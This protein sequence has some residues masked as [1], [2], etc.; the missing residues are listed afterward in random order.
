MAD[1]QTLK[2]K[3]R[4]T[5]YPNGKGAIN[6]TD[7]QALLLDMADGIAKLT[8]LYYEPG[9]LASNDGS[10]VSN[11]AVSRTNFIP[12]KNGDA[13]SAYIYRLFLYDEDYNFIKQELTSSDGK[14]LVNYVISD[15]R[16]RYVRIVSLNLFK[17]SI[18]INGIDPVYVQGKDVSKRFVDVQHDINTLSQD[19]S[20]IRELSQVIEGVFSEE[21]GVRPNGDF[22]SNS[23]F[24][25][26]DFVPLTKD[27]VSIEYNCYITE[28]FNLLC[29]A[30]Y[31]ANKSFISGVRTCLD[32]TR[33]VLRNNMPS[34]ASYIR[35]STLASRVPSTSFFKILTKSFL[36]DDVKDLE[37]RAD[38]L[39][40]EVKSVEDKVAVV[41]DRI[42][43]SLT[44]EAYVDIPFPMVIRKGMNILSI[45]GTTAIYLR[46]QTDSTLFLITAA[47]LPYTLEDDVTAF[48]ST[49]TGFGSIVIDGLLDSRIDNNYQATSRSFLLPGEWG[50]NAPV[51]N[52]NYI[53]TPGFPC[54]Y[55]DTIKGK[56]YALTLLD[57]NKCYLEVI[58]N[59]EEVVVKNVN[60]A[61]GV[62]TLY[63]GQEDI[64][65]LT[66]N[67]K[68]IVPHILQ[69]RFSDGYMYRAA[70]PYSDFSVNSTNL[71]L[72]KD[73]VSLHEIVGNSILGL[74][75]KRGDANSTFHIT[76]FRYR[77]I[78]SEWGNTEYTQLRVVE[79]K[80]DGSTINH[81]VVEDRTSV[82]INDE[83]QVYETSDYL[84]Y[85][86]WRLAKKGLGYALAAGDYNRLNPIILNRLH[87]IY[88]MLL[89]GSSGNQQT[90]I[91]SNSYIAL[92]IPQLAMANI[93]STK[94]PTTKT[95][96][97]QGILEFN[98]MH[99]N[100]F[101]KKIIFN[102]QGNSSLGLDKKNFSIDIMDENYAE[103]HELKF[104][105]WVAQ[106][107]FH[108][109]S[110]M[111][112]G[113]R[114]KAMA[115][116]DVYESILKTRGLT[117][118]RA[119]KRLQLPAD[120]PTTSNDIADTYLQIDDGAKNHPSGFPVIVFHNGVF[121]G[122]YCWQLKKHR[123][124]YHQ[125]KKNSAHIHL[126]GNISNTLLWEANGV[127]DWSKWSGKT[128]ESTEIVN[129]DGIEIRNPKP[130]ILVDGT[131]YDGDTNRGELISKSSANYDAANKNMKRTA[132]VREHLELLS[133]NV[134]RLSSM[135]KGAEKKSA[136]AEVFDVD[137][138]I[139]YIIFSQ[140]VTNLDG[141]KKNWQWVTYDGVK[142]AVNAYD[143]DGTW[144]WTSWSYTSPVSGWIHNDTPPITLIIENYLD[145]IKSRYAE[146][147]KSGVVSL[148]KIVSPLANYVR[149]IGVDYYDLEYAK[150][151]NGGRDNLWRFYAWME[152]SIKRTDALLE[153]VA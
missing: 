54:K 112:D 145:E 64:Y 3:I 57:K 115:V 114:V 75:L 136:I 90:D 142:W 96:D 85:I 72:I 8:E 11:T 89:N 141:Y 69:E 40:A 47:Q 6:A 125:E 80:N 129:Y 59:K 49:S 16:C 153:F 150:W 39:E 29:L 151:T 146:L 78:S 97:I 140:L 30:F 58:V 135:A 63:K 100:A 56:M 133:S 98:D 45:S 23:N 126:D 44:G 19:I 15:N 149:V 41:A 4:S 7:H 143:L 22:L 14:G 24:L 105:D 144:G 87:N 84:L 116:Y 119:W 42:E 92:P 1:I 36:V 103:S 121:Y 106:D 147:R 62:V 9:A 138:I 128:A 55:G 26:S 110:Y 131:E 17:N 91:S 13:I 70:Y 50:L 118:D 66:I 65:S 10:E 104:G 32:E 148:E 101:A 120:I 95:D 18:L 67:D 152:E 127:I 94:L 139:D 71:Q 5:I 33:I 48:Q 25:I 137:S 124:N 38:L 108:L 93:V 117:K 51:E 43:V 21:G 99:G 2:D 77:Q 134:A 68:S 111:L 46:K 79:K 20:D 83:L 52:S 130:L 60:A 82:T 34:N 123:K 61:Y 86:D 28:S 31:D 73:N 81:N 107:G 53:Y 132:E 122:I 109:K 88:L 12:C 102:A 76:N 27:V 37:A 35:I 74:W 113:I